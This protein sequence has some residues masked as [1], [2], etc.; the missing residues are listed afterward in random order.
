MRDETQIS[1]TLLDR[2]PG[3]SCRCHTS[4][5]NEIRDELQLAVAGIGEGTESVQRDTGRQGPGHL[6]GIWKTCGEMVGE[7]HINFT[8]AL[9]GRHNAGKKEK[10]QLLAGLPDTSQRQ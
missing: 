2:E 3:I 4:G 8:L 10:G 9:K 7:S 1:P 5:E 6:Q